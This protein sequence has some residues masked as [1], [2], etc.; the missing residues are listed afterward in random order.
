MRKNRDK[1]LQDFIDLRDRYRKEGKPRS[2]LKEYRE[3]KEICWEGFDYLVLLKAK[4]YKIFP[5][6]PDLVQEGRI[7]LLAS[8]ETFDPKKG[9]FTWWANQYIKTKLSR[10][11]NKHSTMRV[12]MKMARTFSPQKISLEGEEGR[13]HPSLLNSFLGP[14]AAQDAFDQET[15][16]KEVRSAIKGLGPIEQKVVALSA[17][18][19]YTVQQISSM[20]EISPYVC[21]KIL[22][23]GLANLKTSLQKLAIG[24]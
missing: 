23:K 17:L 21:S 9:S 4:K 11:A 22:N 3:K 24:W 5:N 6:Y 7:A 18:Q 13:L 12:P 14:Q 16:K 2:L 10:E 19:D 20:L 8:L 1:E 15:V